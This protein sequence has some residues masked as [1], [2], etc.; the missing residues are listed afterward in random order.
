MS[1]VIY[2]TYLALALYNLHICFLFSLLSI[3]SYF[4]DQIK[5]KNMIELVLID[6]QNYFADKIREKMFPSRLVLPTDHL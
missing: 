3:L 2:N 1:Y 6:Q 5:K 4:D